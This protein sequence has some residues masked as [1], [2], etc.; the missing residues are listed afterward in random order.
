MRVAAAFLRSTTANCGS[1]LR[2]SAA[3][4]SHAFSSWHCADSPEASWMDSEKAGDPSARIGF[5]VL[6]KVMRR[7]SGAE[8]SPP[9]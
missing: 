7:P 9:L 2:T 5:N 6:H 4:F 8:Q 1:F 3:R